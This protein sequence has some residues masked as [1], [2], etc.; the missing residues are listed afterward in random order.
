MHVELQ[1]L[2]SNAT[3]SIVDLPYG[4]VPICCRWI[5][6]IRYKANGTIER[7]KARFV[8][9]G[10]TQMECVDYFDTFSLVAKNITIRVL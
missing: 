5:Y 3:W 7:Y 2:A 9:K 6:K 1:A 8:A 4:K 10:Y